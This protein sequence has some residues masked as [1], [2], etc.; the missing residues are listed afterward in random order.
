MTACQP[1]AA[2][3][4]VWLGGLLTLG[5]CLL[6][7]HLVVWQRGCYLDDLT[8]QDE[9]RQAPV[10]TVFQHRLC[11]AHAWPQARG[12][13]YGAIVLALAAFPEG[14]W[15]IRLLQA[16]LTGL[17]ALLL[18]GL[19]WRLLRSR[20]AVWVT[21]LTFATPVVAHEA[22][23]WVCCVDYLLSLALTLTA[24]HAAWHFLLGQNRPWLGAI[25]T[26]LC[27]VVTLMMK[28]SFLAVYLL[29]PVLLFLGWKNSDSLLTWGGW[30][31]RTLLC[32]GP[33]ALLS[34]GIV[35]VNYVIYPPCALTGRGGTI[36]T[37]GELAAK[38]QDYFGTLRQ[39]YLGRGMKP[40][41]GQ[42]LEKGLGLVSESGLAQ[43]GLGVALVGLLLA[44]MA[45]PTSVSGITSRTN[46]T[47]VL[48]LSLGW[49]LLAL[50]FPNT[51]VKQQ[52]ITPRMLY[53]PCAGLA[54]LTGTCAAG[55]V[56]AWPRHGWERCLVLAGGVGGVLLALLM[57]GYA[58]M[59]AERSQEDQRQWQELQRVL[60]ASEL[61]EGATVVHVQAL[62]Y[63]VQWQ[64][65]FGPALVGLLDA[66]FMLQLRAEKYWGRKDLHWQ[67]LAPWETT[68]GLPWQWAGP[69][70]ILIGGR[71]VP[72]NRLVL[73]TYESG[74]GIRLLD[75]VTLRDEQGQWQTRPLRPRP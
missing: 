29:L 67:V 33:P 18:A 69:D 19:S 32:V 21:L 7:G 17:N 61:P 56:Q 37:A 46:L 58:Q 2:G 6:L 73:F 25:G 1:T 71:R 62:P 4:K 8:L 40:Q 31:R 70:T 26:T 10:A 24:C 35:A 63:F 27:L 72:L 5:A 54:L 41:F 23:L 55:M 9:L 39:C 52:S 16:G 36:T 50:L 30:G 20:I 34:L 74:S 59:Y 12:L 3:W 47:G 64:P 11:G 15:G 75:Q 44:V 28:E 65:P 45:W 49:F 38:T 57:L 66:S 51:L 48:L 53:F 60:P 13:G 43:V 42:P 22:C 14:E 68:R